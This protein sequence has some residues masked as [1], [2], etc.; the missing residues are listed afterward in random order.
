M[1]WILGLLISLFIMY[2]DYAHYFYTKRHGKKSKVPRLL[3]LF[4]TVTLPMLAATEIL[5]E[6]GAGE[7]AYQIRQ[8]EIS[9][10][11]L[12]SDQQRLQKKH[13]YWLS[14]LICKKATT[15]RRFGY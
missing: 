2:S 9:C 6:L 3:S 8:K 15:M 11:G 14:H 1:F 4:I 13:L 5:N 7:V 10:I 12:Y